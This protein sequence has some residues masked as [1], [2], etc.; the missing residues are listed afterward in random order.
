MLLAPR[1]VTMGDTATPPSARRNDGWFVSRDDNH[2]GKKLL[3]PP[4]RVPPWPGLRRE[5]SLVLSLPCSTVIRGVQQQ[6]P[7]WK[8]MASLSS[9]IVL[10]I[11]P[12]MVVSR[13]DD[14]D[15]NN[16]CHQAAS[17]SGHCKA[18]G[19]VGVSM[20]TAFTTAAGED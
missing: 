14:N 12:H 16:G 4:L 17:L 11:R 2:Q 10:V 20:H 1:Y 9:T 18:N 8:L 15:N 5:A 7:W 3:A 6:R 13:S 19:P